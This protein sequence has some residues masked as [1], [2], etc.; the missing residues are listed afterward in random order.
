MSWRDAVRLS[1]VAF[2]EL[3]LQAIY[4][5]RQGNLGPPEPAERMVPRAR[6]RVVQSKAI[7]SFVLGLLAFAVAYAL[8]ESRTVASAFPFAVPP[9]VFDAGL[10]TGL[11]SLDVA[12]LW[13]TG[14]QV[15]PTFLSSGVLPV[16]EP[17]PID[18]TTLS[19]VAG[20]LYLRLFDLPA[21]TV[22]LA[23]PLL[24]GFALGPW[25]GLAVVPGVVAAVG[26]A[27]ALSLLTGRFFVRRV[28]GSRG[29]GGRALVRWIYL[30]L[31]LVPAFAL[32][33]FVTAAPAFF[34]FLSH[35]SVEGPSTGSH[36]L[37]AA[38]PFPLAALPAIASNGAGGFG[39]DP[40]GWLVLGGATAGYLL[41]AVWAFVWVLE[42]VRRMSIVPPAAARPVRP[43]RLDLV[44]RPVVLAVLTK[45][46]RIASR[47]PG[48]A[49]LVLLP[50][51][52]AVAIGL[53]TYVTASGSAA[54]SN[55][56]FAAVTT[57][58]LLATFFGPAFFAIEVFAFA[59]GRTLP[60]ADRS[61][62]GGKVLLVALMYLTASAIVLGI[63]LARVFD[64]AVF[65]LFILAEL[66]G[67]VAASLLE[68]G[69][70]F[71][72]ARRRGMPVT[73]LYA[74]AWYAIFVSVP[75][76]I[77]AAVPLLAFQVARI[78][79]SPLGLT[80][81]GAAALAELALAAPFALG[82]DGS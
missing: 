21:L 20:L 75:G 17:L 47:T 29:G 25:A 31:W 61:L 79:G 59:Y 56:A 6:R 37:L 3:S 12:F 18:D 22:V 30:V 64:P 35:L 1:D 45:D 66:P 38:F 82:R 80:V 53:W 42:S 13:W 44:P 54:A 58:A 24:V 34:D 23:T 33:G 72:R 19:R 52:D 50:I 26:F 2:T 40:L 60:I 43:A 4:A 11:L 74:G 28:Q 76:L 71:R 57:A 32:F 15:L 10:L 78:H 39:L 48:F 36:L 16:L 68:L 55:L 51:L 14:M 73:N 62:L 7:V 81:M 70:L 5:L 41:L 77:V 69:I 9:G 67:V 63:T 46:L 8:H 27:L 65:A 49:F